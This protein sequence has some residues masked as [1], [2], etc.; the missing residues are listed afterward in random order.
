LELRNLA[1][2][3]EVWQQECPIWAALV[4]AEVLGI[5]VGCETI[6]ID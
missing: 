2:S 1:P 4:E 5:E 3:L 6:A